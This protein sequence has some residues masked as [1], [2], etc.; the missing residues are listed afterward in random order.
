MSVPIITGVMNLFSKGVKSIF[1]YKSSKI[2]AELQERG[3]DLKE[4]ELEV[5][6][7]ITEIKFKEYVLQNSLEIDRDFRNFIVE[8]EGAAK[9]VDP[10]VQILRSIIRPIIS[11]WAVGMISYLMFADPEHITNV[12]KNME[13]IPDKLWDI[14]FIVFAFWFGGR[15]VQHIIDKYTTGKVDEAKEKSRGVVDEARESAAGEREVEKER[16]RQEELRVHGAAT[17]E[18]PR[19]RF[20]EEEERKALKK[21]SSSRR[22]SSKRRG[23]K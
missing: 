4:K 20:T 22:S 11:L 9:D 10:K 1:D 5:M 19:D 3:I 2:Q 17:E 14:F 7:Q 6:M 21:K 18:L 15:A 16:T 23:R 13:L 8:Y 12:A